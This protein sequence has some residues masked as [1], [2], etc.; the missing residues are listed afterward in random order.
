ME[1]LQIQW[2]FEIS[3]HFKYYIFPTPIPDAKSVFL[4]FWTSK[5][6]PAQK[7]G[8]EKTQKHIENRT[9]YQGKMRSQKG[10]GKE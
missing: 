9:P 10:H 4:F 5:I 2:H 7:E 8:L 1:L 6:L 3:N